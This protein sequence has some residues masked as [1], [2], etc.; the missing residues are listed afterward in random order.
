M[1]TGSGKEKTMKSKWLA[2]ILGFMILAGRPLAGAAGDFS[3]DER[4]P[5]IEVVFVFDRGDLEAVEAL[6][7][8]LFSIAN[9]MAFS[10]DAPLINIGMAGYG[11]VNAGATELV[12]FEDIDLVY[13]RLSLTGTEIEKEGFADFY[14]A[15]DASISRLARD[16]GQNLYR[17]I[18]ILSAGNPPGPDPGRDYLGLAHKARESG[19][20]INAIHCG[21]ETP[22]QG[23]S[24]EIS[25]AAGGK[26][27]TVSRPG[28]AAPGPTPFDEELITLSR[29]LDSTRVY[30]G[31]PEIASERARRAQV[32]HLIYTVAPRK[33]RIARAQFNASMPGARNLVGTGELIDEV[34]SEKVEL[35]DIDGNM[36]PSAMR[37]MTMAQ[38][39]AM[40]EERIL[41]RMEIQDSIDTLGEQRQRYILLEFGE[42]G[43]DPA[44]SIDRAMFDCLRSQAGRH[45]INYFKGPLF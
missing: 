30:Y 22:G 33:V 25:E 29:Q 38:R 4:R 2:M 41:R 14:S 17:A 20:I 42:K 3:S 9:T 10:E 13:H 11:G 45:G 43:V 18:F 15:L 21:P 23:L 32:A 31:D 7:H 5:G 19:I 8:K 26:Y 44:D 37:A 28:N 27:L 1:E 34:W 35:A 6:Q 12:L 24:G 16:R 36:L 40:V 39:D